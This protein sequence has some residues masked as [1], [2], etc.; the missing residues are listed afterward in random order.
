MLKKVLLAFTGAAGVVFVAFYLLTIPML[1]RLPKQSHVSMDG[2]TIVL[3]GTDQLSANY[4]KEINEVWGAQLLE[5]Y[6]STEGGT[7]AFE[8][9]YHEGLHINEDFV[10]VEV[11]DG[12]LVI[13]N[14]L[15]FVMHFLTR[16][17]YW[18]YPALVGFPMR[19]LYH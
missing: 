3:V 5:C 9:P 6:A 14:H 11:V 8:C 16:S 15:L 12:H 7:I 19:G 10:L 1:R 13:T 2:V 17:S 18:M 4:R